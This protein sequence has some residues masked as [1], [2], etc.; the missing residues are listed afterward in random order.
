VS[1]R[2]VAAGAVS[3]RGDVACE[4]YDIVANLGAQYSELIGGYADHAATL[5]NPTYHLPDGSAG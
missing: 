3:G 4:S 1:T 5:P 2:R